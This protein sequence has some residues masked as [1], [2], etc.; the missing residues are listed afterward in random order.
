MGEKNFITGDMGG[1][2]WDASLVKNGEVSLKAGDWLND[3][4]LEIKVADVVSI[5]AG[6][7]SIDG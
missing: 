1:T 3:D 6:G 4:R 7:G 5:G 2:T